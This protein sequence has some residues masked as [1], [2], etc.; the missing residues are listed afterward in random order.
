MKPAFWSASTP[1]AFARPLIELLENDELRR[2]MGAHGMA[3]CLANFEIGKTIRDLEDYYFAL[4]R[5]A[6]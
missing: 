3:R 1:E 5:A 2:R 4:V 6:G